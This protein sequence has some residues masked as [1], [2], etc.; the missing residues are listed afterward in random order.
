ML[1]TRE[2]LVCESRA[3]YVSLARVL[4][5]LHLSCTVSGIVSNSNRANPKRLWSF[6]K[7]KRVDNCGVPALKLNDQIHYDSYSKSNILNNYFHSVFTTDNLTNTPIADNNNPYPDITEMHVTLNGVY[8][9][10]KELKQHKAPGPDLIL[11]RLLKET[12]EDIAP[13]LTLL[14]QAS[15]KQSKVPSEWKHA[16]LSPIFKKGDRSL[17]SNYR[18]ISLTRVCSKLLEHIIYTAIMK[19]L[20]IYNILTDAQH[21]FIQGHSCD[22]QLLLT[23]HD[24]ATGL[25][26]GKQI[27]AIALDFTKAFDKVMHRCLHLRLHYYGIR[28]TV[29]DWID[30]F[31][32]NHSQQVVLD[33][34]FS[35]TLPVTSGVPQGTVLGPLLFL[36]FVNNIP[37]RVSNKIR[38][39]ADDILLYKVIDNEDDCIDLQKDLDSLQQWE[40]TW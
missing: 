13:T 19:H 32:T 37:Q 38:L 23:V 11:N 40:N 25:D 31:L 26:N 3:N 5:T 8:K 30:N 36:C 39:Y 7:S 9:L 34:C 15:I 21:G 35:D 4:A 2:S 22:S 12:A 33:G 16:H 28:G 24:I 14:F 17:P 10:L 1:V 27:D 6:I 20:V 29:L 18:P